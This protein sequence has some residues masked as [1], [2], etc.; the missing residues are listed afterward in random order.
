MK[1]KESTVVSRPPERNLEDYATGKKK[2]RKALRL[3]EN[4]KQDSSLFYKNK[5]NR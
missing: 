3:Y 4:K 2:R 1:R 5:I